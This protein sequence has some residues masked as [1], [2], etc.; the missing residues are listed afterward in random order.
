M[1]I[2]HYKKSDHNQFLYETTGNRMVGEIID[3]LVESNTAM[4]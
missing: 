3:E 2:L 1:V 4:T